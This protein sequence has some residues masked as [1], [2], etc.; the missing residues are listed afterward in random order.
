MRRRL[1]MSTK[2]TVVLLLTLAALGCDHPAIHEERFIL[3]LRAL[4]AFDVAV[5]DTR[6]WADG[7]ELGVTDLQGA[8][9]A[10]LNGHHGQAVSL[11]VAC[12]PAY[13]TLTQNRRV[14]LQRIER[15]A[16]PQVSD[17]ELTA[18]CEPLERSA[19]VV[20]RARGPV[21]MGLP[22]RIGGE[23]AGQTDPDG[24]AHLL[25]RTRPHAT[26]RVQ[27]GTSAHPELVPH[28]PVQSFQLGDEDSIL[29]VDQSFAHAP[30]KH[31]A[32]HKPAAA[33]ATA[34]APYRID[35]RTTR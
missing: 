35:S 6:F 3:G 24:T 17:F 10:E 2:R 14:V 23:T 8:L 13:R 5:A 11:S 26:V 9:R 7:R 28:D 31:Y 27:L 16:A 33:P 20:V 21:T 29:L 25:V 30:T 1:T 12:P 19:V 18:R 4:T 32:R 34:H 15:K 22:I